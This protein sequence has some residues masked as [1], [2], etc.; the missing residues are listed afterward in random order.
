MSVAF[1][2]AVCS[3]PIPRAPTRPTAP[4]HLTP[5]VRRP[6]PPDPFE[7]K[8]RTMS[9]PTEPPVADPVAP[10]EPTPPGE[11][12]DVT[13]AAPGDAVPPADVEKPTAAEELAAFAGAL[14]KS[15][16]AE[17]SLS[18]ASFVRATIHGF[19]AMF[20]M[21]LAWASAMVALT[22]FLI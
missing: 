13:T 16:S 11:S 22:L 9:S 18:V 8:L 19:A 21:V 2:G 1:A 10:L 5:C 15:A 20:A 7:R 3:S 4:A 12:P 17:W 6:E 14:A